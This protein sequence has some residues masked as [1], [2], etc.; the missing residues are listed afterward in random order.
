MNKIFFMLN[1]DGWP[2][3]GPNSEEPSGGWNWRRG[4]DVPTGTG[5]GR[6]ATLFT[7]ARTA[8]SSADDP[9]PD[10]QLLEAWE[11]ARWA[12]TSV[13]AQPLRILFVRKGDARDRL[14]SHMFDSNQAKTAGAPVVAV[15]AID[16]RFHDQIPTVFPIR[17]AMTELFESDSELR[18]NTGMFSG[19]LQAAYFI[20]ALRAG[21]PGGRTDGRLRYRGR[22]P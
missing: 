18:S 8:H 11:L 6:T 20:M 5:R 7:R 10:D 21:R 2:K 3:A 12:P 14:I 13:N 4:R 15:L 9:V 19:A 22:R 16:R 1:Q 17:P